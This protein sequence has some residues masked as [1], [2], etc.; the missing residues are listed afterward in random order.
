MMTA[1]C[2]RQHHRY[3][4]PLLHIP[5]ITLDT[6]CNLCNLYTPRNLCNLG[7]HR[8]TLPYKRLDQVFE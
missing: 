5:L 4:I 8:L 7:P 3:L 1:C 2:R 6:L